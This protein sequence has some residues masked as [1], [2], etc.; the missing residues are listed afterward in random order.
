VTVRDLGHDGAREPDPDRG[1]GILLMRKLMDD[2]DVDVD[3]PHGGIVTLRRRL[4]NGS[5]TRTPAFASRR[6][7]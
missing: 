7:V 1:R 4:R 2:A 6:H 5:A 3:G